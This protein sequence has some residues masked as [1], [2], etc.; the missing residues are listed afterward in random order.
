MKDETTNSNGVYNKHL[1]L[2]RM[3]WRWSCSRG[4]HQNKVIRMEKVADR[5]FSWR[6]V[7]LRSVHVAICCSLNFGTILT[8]YQHLKVLYHSF[9]FGNRKLHKDKALGGTPTPLELK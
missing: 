9:G 6:R 5:R 1:Y 3:S 2:T 8:L 4:K 7:P